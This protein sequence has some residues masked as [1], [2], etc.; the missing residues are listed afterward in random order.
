MKNFV[1]PGRTV[2]VTAPADVASGS[3]VIVGSLFG[4]AFANAVSG[5]AVEIGTEGVFELPK[6]SAQAWAEGA[7]VYWDGTAKEATTT[8]SGNTLIGH[9]VA[10]AANPSAT[11]KVRLSI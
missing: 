7:K 8:V 11:G 4:V 1:Q 3:I 10:V 6:T 9:A 5:A 2:T